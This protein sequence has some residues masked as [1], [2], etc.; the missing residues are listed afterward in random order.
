MSMSYGAAESI[1]AD[2]YAVGHDDALRDVAAEIGVTLHPRR[3]AE[4]EDLIA[5][6][7]AAIP[8]FAEWMDDAPLAGVEDKEP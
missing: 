7:R 6:M 3:K 4:V 1:H 5:A 8:G 2:G